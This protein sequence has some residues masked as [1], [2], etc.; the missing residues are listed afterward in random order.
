MTPGLGTSDFSHRRTAVPAFRF[1]LAG[2]GLKAYCSAEGAY[3]S[4]ALKWRR[5]R[6]PSPTSALFVWSLTGSRAGGTRGAAPAMGSGA[7]CQQL[8]RSAGE[9]KVAGADG[10]AVI[11]SRRSRQASHRMAFLR[12]GGPARLITTAGASIASRRGDHSQATASGRSD[13]RCTL[14]GGLELIRLLST[15]FREP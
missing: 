9:R 8:A 5:S 11:S 3:A 13:T 7:G 15:G 1:A 14:E 4:R 10:V 6:C 12:Q 2:V